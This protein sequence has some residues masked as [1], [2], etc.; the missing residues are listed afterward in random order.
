MKLS[1][2]E[3]RKL[4]IDLP[5]GKLSSSFFQLGHEVEEVESTYRDGLIM[6]QIL[7][8]EKHPH[9]DK[10][11]LC[12]VDIGEETLQII[13]GAPNVYKGQKVIVAQVGAFA[14]GQ[15][16]QPIEIKGVKSNGMICS[17]AEIGFSK[18]LL[19]TED[20]DGIYDAPVDI[21]VGSN[22]MESLELGD[23]IMDLFLTANRGD[24][25]SYRGLYNDLIAVINYDNSSD[26][27]VYKTELPSTLEVTGDKG[28][29]HV[30]DEELVQ[31]Y[32]TQL[33][34]NIEVKNTDKQRKIFLLKHGIKE[35]NNI[36]DISNEVLLKFGIPS[37]IYDADT[38]VG[39]I[40]VEL[41]TQTEE[42][43]GLD[44]KA[45][46]IPAGIL[47]IR[48]SEKIIAIAGVMGSE[49]TK[50]TSNT[51]NILLEVASFD[52]YHVYKA[53]KVIGKKTDAVIRYE[54]GIDLGIIKDIN[55]IVVREILEDSSEGDDQIVLNEI[56]SSKL[57]Q[58]D[59]IEI[60]LRKYMVKKLLGI[61]LD[62]EDIVKI[63][64][65]L[66][67]KI[68]ENTVDNIKVEIPSQRKD[69]FTENDLVEE[70]MRI[71][72]IENLEEDNSISTFISEEEIV[73][74]RTY[75]E[76]VNLENRMLRTGLNETITYSLISKKQIEQ[77]YG[78]FNAE[79]YVSL[80]SPLSKEHE[81]YRQSLVPSLLEVA[82][83]NISRQEKQVS[84][85]EVGNVYHK[86]DSEIVEELK[87]SSLLTG[88]NNLIYGGNK[89]YY[90]FAD[91]RSKLEQLMESYGLT[92]E[93][94]PS[95]R[96]IAAVNPYA[97]GDIMVEGEN[98]GF[99]GEVVFDYFKKFKY[100]IYVFELS[101]TKL[102]ELLSQKEMIYHVISNLPQ[103]ERDITV[104][105]DREEIF[106][107]VRE[108]FEGISYLTNVK[109]F[110]VYTGENMNPNRKTLTFKLTF[111]DDNKTLTNEIINEEIE[112]IMIAINAKGYKVNR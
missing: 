67:F 14:G 57:I 102:F 77:F 107:N 44:G 73:K 90:S 15:E 38:I 31:Y 46:E 47:V 66:H 8:L 72:N 82:K 53:S 101:V 105:V 39:D 109:L 50:I 97:I 83:N 108:I 7:E 18:D 19:T 70:I 49:A 5:L 28:I 42:F 103:V 106:A 92:L 43:L 76:I 87:L 16:I 21:K 23:D 20:V 3:L 26:I 27:D 78:D 89:E 64:E 55:N 2:K 22:P 71:Y 100:P 96:E 93:V 88:E 95:S 51:K 110:D 17:L 58:E 74:N 48:D 36:T 80:M 4:G 68:L 24:C 10:L 6:G 12:Q 13:C 111:R 81:Y 56:R 54:K 32:S 61:R 40:R 62:G 112:K 52:P 29:S 104:E 25:Q 33:L 91:L 35:Q 59:L 9:A 75:E 41:T 63:F 65:A 1:Y 45:V 99:I 85:F 60:S 11:N 34:E 30:V 37:H 79:E 98:I 69:L 94:T 86:G 84:I